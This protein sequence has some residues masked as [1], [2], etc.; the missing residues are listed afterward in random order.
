MA[1]AM[2]PAPGVGDSVTVGWPCTQPRLSHD[3]VAALYQG[4]P[5][6]AFRAVMGYEYTPMLHIW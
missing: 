1:P 6:Y 5:G 2:V 3:C 4:L